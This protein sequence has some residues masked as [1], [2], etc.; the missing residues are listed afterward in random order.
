[1]TVTIERI[2]EVIVPGKRLGRHI[3]PLTREACEPHPRIG[4]ELKSVVHAR[5]CPILDQGNVGSCTGNATV[6][7]LGTTPVYDTLPA[8]HPVLNESL[9]LKIYSA[10][11]MIDGDGPYPPN[12]NGSTGPSV[13]Q[14]A[15]NDKYVAS[16]THYTDIDSALQSLQD[17]PIMV[18]ANWYSSF[19]TPAADGT[20][21]IAKGAYVRGGHEFVAREYDAVTQMITFDNSWGLSYGVQGRFKMSKATLTRLLSEGGDAT[22]LVPLAAPVPVPV[23]TPTPTPTPVPVPTP[24]PTPKPTPKPPKPSWIDDFIK[25]LEGFFA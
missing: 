9:A 22:V 19:D 14:V 25:W 23:P 6:G 17:A 2:P 24:T 11:E 18:G 10:A 20:V 4:R 7:A 8:G 16:F 15:V 13:G 1:M 5:H 12:D 3:H 21:V